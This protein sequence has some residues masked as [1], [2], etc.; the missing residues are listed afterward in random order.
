MKALGNWLVSLA[1][2]NDDLYSSKRSWRS[3]YT[4]STWWWVES[5]RFVVVAATGSLLTV[6]V[7]AVLILADVVHMWV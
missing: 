5:V 3:R 1:I 7:L 6:F 2:A 4:M